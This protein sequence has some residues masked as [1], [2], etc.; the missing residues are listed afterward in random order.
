VS[1][2]VEHVA[3]DV[4]FALMLALERLSPLERAA[5]LLHDIFELEFDEIATALHRREATCRQLVRRARSHVAA[6][7][8]RFT[9]NPAEGANIAEA[10]FKASR[11]GDT[12]ALRDLLADTVLLHTDGGGRKP[13][14]LNV[15]FGAGKVGRYFGGLF[16]KGKVVDPLWTKRVTIN[17]LPGLATLEQDGTLQTMA[18]EIANGRIDAIYVTRNPD[19]LGQLAPFLPDW[20]AERIS[21]QS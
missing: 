4:S 7:R 11:S 14:A 3:D 19:K 8:P 2:P 17:G 16:R 15:I 10:F 20:A 18:L 1:N 9:V 6:E 5:F 13:A 21:D 12:A